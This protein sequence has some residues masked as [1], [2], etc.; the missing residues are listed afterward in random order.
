MGFQNSKMAQD[1]APAWQEHALD[2]SASIQA[3]SLATCA[4]QKQ[5]LPALVYIWGVG[6]LCSA[7]SGSDF[8]EGGE[9][10]FTGY[11]E[12]QDYYH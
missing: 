7:S 2:Y 11:E 1:N 10:L 8:S 6:K 3:G 4:G 5:K 9:R 12:T